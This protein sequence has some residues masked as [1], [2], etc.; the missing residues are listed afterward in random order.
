V[1]FASDFTDR[2]VSFC[3]SV[4]SVLLLLFNVVVDV[5]TNIERSGQR[6]N[7]GR[8]LERAEWQ[9]TDVKTKGWYNS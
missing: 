1:D 4:A 2:C 3:W 6:V 9:S 5:D 7:D 8:V